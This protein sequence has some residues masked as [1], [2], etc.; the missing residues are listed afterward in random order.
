MT[1]TE[2]LQQ[3]HITAA[4][5]GF[6]ADKAQL[7]KK[8]FDWQKDI[9]V[10]ALKKG[11]CAL[12]EDCGLGKTLQQLM[13]AQEV[14]RKTNKPVLILA[15]L[16]VV[17]QTAREGVKF[18]ID[19]NICRTSDDVKN[20]IN[21]TNYEMLNHFDMSQFSGIVL[22]E[23]SILKDYTSSTKQSLVDMCADVPYRLCC[24]A[25]PSPNDYTELGNHAEFLAIMSRSEMLATFFVHDMGDTQ[26]WRL[27]GHAQ[28]AFFEWVASWACCVTSPRDLGYDAE[29]YDLPPLNVI[30]HIVKTD[31]LISA[32]GQIMFAPEVTQTL[33]ERRQARRDSMAERVQLAADIANNIDGQCLVWCDL[34]AESMALA[35]SID[36]ACEVTGSDAPDAKV[37]A[38]N[39]FTDGVVRCIVSKPKIAGWGMNWQNC[40]EVV[41]VG[42]SDSFEAYYQAVR[43]CWRFG[44][45]K[46]VNV[47]IVI[48][49]A[50]GAVKA[51]IERKQ[52]D[53]QNLTKQ[54]VQHT[55]DILKADIQ[56]TRR[57]TES[58]Y[59]RVPLR[60]PQWI[61]SE[62]A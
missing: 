47:H 28:S 43:R 35:A 21:I 37:K 1:Y 48:S 29:G 34:N 9:T 25:T 60:I 44:Q 45:T 2:F 56:Q 62:T 55:K 11:K 61:R 18:G 20:A 5:S 52:R 54:L 53:A 51:N 4:T 58:Y 12:F 49:D 59:A 30:E 23:S 13:W 22:D 19:V 3:K 41:F 17:Q 7:N 16:A 26:K 15:P 40:N 50:E 31:N 57:I 6:D 33:N 36:G 8:A 32:D 10:W 38:M 46:P 27:K 24:T 39:G 42:L 14:Q